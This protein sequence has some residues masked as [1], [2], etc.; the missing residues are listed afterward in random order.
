MK[1]TNKG[2]RRLQKNNESCYRKNKSNKQRRR[3]VTNKEEKS[4]KQK[5]MEVAN[6]RIKVANERKRTM[7]CAL[8]SDLSFCL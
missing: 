2:E 4:Y 7:S 3:K 8:N 1:V 6:E 5:I